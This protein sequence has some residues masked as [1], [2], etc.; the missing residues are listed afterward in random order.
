MPSCRARRYLG[1]Q[2]QSLFRS[3]FNTNANAPANATI[4]SAAFTTMR[5]GLL[6]LAYPGSRAAIRSGSRRSRNRVLTS[7]TL[8]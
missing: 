2:R 6:G 1:D 4:P 8:R 7:A 5:S 3:D